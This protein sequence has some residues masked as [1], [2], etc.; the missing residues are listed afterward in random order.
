ML[1]LLFLFS[2]LFSILVP[3]FCPTNYFCLLTLNLVHSCSVVLWNTGADCLFQSLLLWVAL[4]STD[5]PL[6]TA[7]PNLIGLHVVC[8]HFR[9]FDRIFFSSWFHYLINWL[10]KVGC[11]VLNFFYFI[12][13]KKWSHC[14]RGCSEPTLMAS[15]HWSC[16]LISTYQ[17][18]GFHAGVSTQSLD[19]IAFVLITIF[20]LYFYQNVADLLHLLSKFSIF[21][22]KISVSD[23]IFLLSSSSFLFYECFFSFQA[24]RFKNF[25]RFN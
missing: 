4:M 3:C 11:L 6:G 18:L 2:V 8:G 7:F 25:V 12:L 19:F 15:W 13:F 1:L 14:T 22:I 21:L 23:I 20:C 5:F 16:H 9:L 10:L 24:L 17:V